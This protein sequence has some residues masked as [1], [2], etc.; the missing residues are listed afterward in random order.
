MN[1]IKSNQLH[2]VFCFQFIP[3]HI[4]CNFSLLSFFYF[5]SAARKTNETVVTKLFAGMVDIHIQREADTMAMCDHEN[6][7]KFFAL[8][9]VE[10]YYRQALTMQYCSEGDLQKL[11]DSQP[12][13]LSSF[14]FSQLFHHLVSAVKHLHEKCIVHRDIK[15]AN[16]MISKNCHGSSIYKLGDFGAA[17]VLQADQLYGS[18]YGTFEYAHPDIF[19]KMYLHAL[20]LEIPPV[21]MFG[22]SHEWWS[23][24]ITLYEAAT[25]KLPFKPQNGRN[26]PKTMYTMTSEKEKCHIAALQV[27]GKIEWSQELPPNCTIEKKEKVT[28]LLA[29]L[30]NVSILLIPIT[31]LQLNCLFFLISH[32]F[33]TN[34]F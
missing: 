6:I 30:L 4:I 14:E 19:A 3:T 23:I 7:V 31:V 22:E 13:G 28:Q 8:E 18:M 25:S 15:P 20:D 24:G 12:D 34:I 17:R 5:K 11:I 1:I 2:D 9:K 29:G 21:R 16:I 10:G 27:G 32:F 26:D 33:N